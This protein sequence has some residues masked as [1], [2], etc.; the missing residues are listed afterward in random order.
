MIWRVYKVVFRLRSPMHIGW[1]KVSNLQMTRPYVTG[2]AL[3]G[4]LTARLTRNT[5]SGLAIDS[6]A[7]QETGKKVHDTLAFTYFYPALKKKDGYQVVW[8]WG[9]EETDFCRRFISSYVSTALVYPQHSAAEGFL[10]EVEFLSPRTLDTGEP[11][12]LVGYVFARKDDALK[13]REALRYLQLG[14]ER[15]YGWGRVEL[16]VCLEQKDYSLFDA[17]ATVE[18][19]GD[20][21]AIVL[22]RDKH[23]L[24][25]TAHTGAEDKL[26][27][28]GIDGIIGIIEPLV[29]REWSDQP[30]QKVVPDG[31]Y[32][33]PG[34]KVN[35]ESRRFRIGK[36]GLWELA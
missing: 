29:G 8:P 35:A 11:V 27:I 12:Y 9:N 21:P 22:F 25:H 4:A 26:T 20:R 36:F 3:W 33:A 17:A 28:D 1:R 10:H 32:Y 15:G 6:T 13:W 5:S 2:R 34:S 23:L 24:A 14:G 7:Y 19:D 18:I 31:I 16:V 30:G